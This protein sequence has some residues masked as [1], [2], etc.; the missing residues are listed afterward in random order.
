M[1]DNIQIRR[2]PAPIL[3]HP[4]QLPLMRPLKH[5]VARNMIPFLL[6]ILFDAPQHLPI[7]HPRR[8]Q[9]R[10]EV[11]DA[12]MPVRTAMALATSRRMLRQDFLARKG[13]ISAAPPQRVATHVAVRVAHVVAVL[14]VEGVVGDEAEGAAPEEQAVLK[15][16]TQALEEERVLQAAEVLQVAVGA[17][18]GMQVAHTEGEVLREGINGGSGDG[19]AGEGGVCICKGGVRGRKVLGQVR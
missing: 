19:R 17:K 1:H 2:A 18:G 6:H 16:E 13:R 3:P 11:V 15:G 4:L 14:F 9:Q 8:L 7:V 12:E 10:R 5:S